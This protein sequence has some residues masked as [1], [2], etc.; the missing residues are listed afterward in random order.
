MLYDE[1]LP[2]SLLQRLASGMARI[3]DPPLK[4]ALR[5]YVKLYSEVEKPVVVDKGNYLISLGSTTI[6][7][8]AGPTSINVQCY[9]NFQPVALMIPPAVASI[10]SIVDIKVGKNSQMLSTKTLP[11]T[12]FSYPDGTPILL[13]MEKVKCGDWIR[14]TVASTIPSAVGLKEFTGVLLGRPCHRES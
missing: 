5:H 6:D 14:L 12:F 10:F 1:Q 9:E 13:Q 2:P 7:L 8:M 11:A 3:I 4:L